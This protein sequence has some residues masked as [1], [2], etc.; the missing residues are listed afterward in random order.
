MVISRLDNAVTRGL[1][2]FSDLSRDV[3]RRAEEIANMCTLL[4]RTFH[5]SVNFS[6]VKFCCKFAPVGVN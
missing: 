2:F 6:G 1:F 3:V 5:R 4:E